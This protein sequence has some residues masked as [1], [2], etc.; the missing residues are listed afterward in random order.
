[1]DITAISGALEARGL[2]LCG[3]FHPRPGDGVPALSGGGAAAALV[4]AGNQGPGLWRAFRDGPEF[5]DGA[6]V[7]FTA[8]RLRKGL[9]KRRAGRRLIL[10]GPEPTFHPRLPDLIREYSKKGFPVWIETTA[11]TG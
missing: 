11:V 7:Y 3:A 1:M 4:L 6:P 2:F 10:C 8:R 5:R 9:P